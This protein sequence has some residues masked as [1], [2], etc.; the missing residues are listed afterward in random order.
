MPLSW[1]EIRNRAHEFSRKWEGE[2]SER[3]EAQYAAIGKA[4]VEWANIEYLL[5]VLLARLLATPVFLARTFIA[6]ISAVRLQ[7]AIQEAVEI[8]RIR[9]RERIV[10]PELLNE[11]IE[12]NKSITAL[13]AMRNK[14]SHFCWT[15]SS[16]E[17]VFGT[18]FTGGVPTPKSERKNSKVITLSELNRLHRNSYSL[19][20]RLLEI[21]QRLPEVKEESLLTSR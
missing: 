10:A 18:S 11:I 12:I 1:N 16:D 9:Y 15:R 2:E 14:I 6:P 20:E 17:A 8:H 4:V 5:G 13:R 21:V 3:A 7:E 19:V